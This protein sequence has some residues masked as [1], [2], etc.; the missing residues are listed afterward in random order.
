MFEQQLQEHQKTIRSAASRGP[1][2]RMALKSGTEWADDAILRLD[3]DERHTISEFHRRKAEWRRDVTK[4]EKPREVLE[5]THTARTY[6][7]SGRACIGIELLI[8]TGTMLLIFL[9]I[10]FSLAPAALLALIL[11]GII[12]VGL[13]LAFHGG[14]TYLVKRWDDPL[15]SINRLK[16]RFILPAF[17][18]MVFSVIAYV[19]IQRLDADTVLLLQPVLAISKF[20]AMLGFMVLGTALLVAA[21]LLNW[22]QFRAKAYEANRNERQTIISKRREWQEQLAG[23]EQNSN[24]ALQEAAPPSSDFKPTEPSVS[25]NG[26]AASVPQSALGSATLVIV[27]ALLSNLFLSA[28]TAQSQP[29][30]LAQQEN[31]SCNVIMDA[32]GVRYYSGLQHAG[33]NVLN[34]LPKM[35][36]QQHI[37]ELSTFWFGQNGWTVERK[38]HI[39][40]RPYARVEM[41]ERKPDDLE[42]MRPDVGKA[43]REKDS[44]LLKELERKEQSDYDME[45]RRALAP[46]TINE[47]IPPAKQES[48]CTDVN[49][50]LSRFSQ[51]NSAGLQIV[52]LVTDGRQNCRKNYQIDKVAYDSQVIIIVMIVPGTKEDGREDY[53]AKAASFEQ[54]CP[55]CSVVPYYREDL[56]QLVAE[57]VRKN[58]GFSA[59]MMK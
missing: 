41:P 55:Q 10:G 22:S 45:V 52:L 15:E 43:Q 9:A 33:L 50:L 48:P 59:A 1:E 30:R 53:R 38:V 4:D 12:T 40:F 27:C 34:G 19:A 25:S 44:K 7:I 20:T 18:L 8:A 42:K 51:R 21:E 31:I 54:A 14:I 37:G 35:V 47:L 32:S 39:L 36:E 23:L 13:V 29:R 6:G 58:V 2:R 3:D 28:C 11:A 49:G 46:L 56:D 26:K 57:A 24:E 17:V 16:K 5:Q